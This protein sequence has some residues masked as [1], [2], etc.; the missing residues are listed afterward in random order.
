MLALEFNTMDNFLNANYNE[1]VKIQDI[2]FIICF[3]LTNLKLF[4]IKCGIL[5]GADMTPGAG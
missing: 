2:E 1:L 4:L 3:S 5:R